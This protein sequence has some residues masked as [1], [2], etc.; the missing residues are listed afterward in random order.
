MNFDD[1]ELRLRYP[2]LFRDRDASR[3]PPPAAGPERTLPATRPAARFTGWI[4]ALTGRCRRRATWRPP[5]DVSHG[6][7]AG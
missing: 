5:A 4:V 7:D 2:Q 1:I 6:P 3:R